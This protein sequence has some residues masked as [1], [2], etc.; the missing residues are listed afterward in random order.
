MD[1]EDR[2][3][4][5]ERRIAL[6][7]SFLDAELRERQHFSQ[8]DVL[9][10]CGPINPWYGCSLGLKVTPVDISPVE[11]KGAVGRAV[12]GVSDVEKRVGLTKPDTI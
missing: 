7:E 4:E 3:A 11:S 6:I 1:A 12:S 9:G 5:L 2:L 10:G 8:L